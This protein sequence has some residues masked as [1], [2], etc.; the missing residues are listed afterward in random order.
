[1]DATVIVIGAGVAGLSCARDLVRRGVACVVLERARGVGGRCATRRVEGQAVDHGVAFLHAR[2]RE[3]G[4]VLRELDAAGAIPGWPL[5]VRG[6]EM[7]CQANAYRPGRRRV[8]RREGVSSLPKHLARGVDV[9]LGA[10]V[11]AIEPRG[12]R[13]EVIAGDGA[14]WTAPYVVAAGAVDESAALVAPTVEGWPDAAAKL[15]RIRAVPVQP[16]FTVV[17]GYALDSPEPGFDVAH[18]IEATMLHTISHDSGKRDDPRFRVL[19]LQGRSQW[20]R[21][22]SAVPDAEWRDELLWEAAELLGAWAMKPLWT[23]CHRWRSAR[24]LERHQLGDPVVFL[25]PGGCAVAVIGDAFARDPGLEGAYMSG[26]A[27]A[28]QIREAPGVTARG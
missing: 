2:S 19:V 5:T 11:R 14:R 12:P 23:Q 1:M 4:D 21:E 22:R 27:L 7:A 24:V 9:R 16:A 18:P 6:P 15:D 3:F 25:G 26:I 28:E 17:A 20:S 13:L 8:G 10:D